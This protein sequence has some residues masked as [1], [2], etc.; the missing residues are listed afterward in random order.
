VG[1]LPFIGD[2]VLAFGSL[3]LSQ[4][5][6]LGTV[7]F[8]YRIDDHRPQHYVARLTPKGRVG[9]FGDRPYSFRTPLATRLR[10]QL[11]EELRVITE[12]PSTARKVLAR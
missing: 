3:P 11:E 12:L 8:P 6:V 7:P 1:Q 4:L 5:L 2:L 9:E 10:R